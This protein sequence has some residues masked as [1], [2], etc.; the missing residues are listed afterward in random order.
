MSETD[1]VD[2]TAVARFVAMGAYG[3]VMLRFQLLEMS[4][5]SILAARKP[6]GMSLHQHIAKLTEWDRQTGERLIKARGLPDDLRDGAMTAVNTRNL[7]AHRF[8]RERAVFFSDPLASHEAAKVLVKVEVKVDEFE[9]R[10]NAYMRELGI[11][12]LDESTIEALELA[13]PPDFATWSALFDQG[14]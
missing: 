6:P 7:L 8:L 5:W 2:D 3:E 14:D 13:V 4:Y 9:E 10:L 12:E 11:E 1:E